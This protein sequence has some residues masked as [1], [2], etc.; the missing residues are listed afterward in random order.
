MRKFVKGFDQVRHKT[1][2]NFIDMD[3]ESASH[4]ISGV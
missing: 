3:G 1:V 4:G 2:L